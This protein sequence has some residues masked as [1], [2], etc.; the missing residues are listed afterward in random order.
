MKNPFSLSFGKEPASLIS[1]EYQSNE[2]IDSFTDENPAYQVCVITG[3]RGAG[4]TVALTTIANRLRREPQWVV[5]DLN[6]EASDLIHMLAAELSNRKELLQLFRDAKIN[7]SFLGFG[8]EIDGEP[9]ITDDT[10]ALRRMLEKLTESGKRILVTIDEASS[11]PQFRVFASQFQ[12]F[13]RENLQVFLLMTGL[14][15]NISELQ[16]SKNLTFLYRAPK[17]K[18]RPLNLTLVARKYRETFNLPDS[19]ATA[20]ARMTKGY[21]FA[22]QALGYLCWTRKL[23]WQDVL[24]DFDVCM[25][26]N[27]YEKIWSELSETDQRTVRA[28]CTAKDQKVES[29]RAELHMDSNNFNVYRKRLIRRG[30]VSCPRRGYL[31]LSLPRFA[32]FVF[33]DY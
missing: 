18:L 21:P 26:E 33:Q 19:E 9:P 10:V 2:I 29:I 12:I 17:L 32:E 14:Y 23:P 8:L 7:L 24:T 20:M 11:T 15:E 25:E 27:V 31:E 16:D 30:I 28:I 1:R 13:M 3:V 5:V 4:K 6:P 22:F